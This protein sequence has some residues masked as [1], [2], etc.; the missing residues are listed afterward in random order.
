MNDYAKRMKKEHIDLS[1]TSQKMRTLLLEV[2]GNKAKWAELCGGSQKQV[3]PETMMKVFALKILAKM[4][5]SEDPYSQKV[6]TPKE[7]PSGN[8]MEGDSEFS[9]CSF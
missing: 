8:L 9:Y 5:G 7:C 6:S 4:N 1:I 2:V 3:C